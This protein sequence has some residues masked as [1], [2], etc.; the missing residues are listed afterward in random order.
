MFHWF[1]K[2]SNLSKVRQE[3]LKCHAEKYQIPINNFDL[4]DTALTHISCIENNHV[5][6]YERLE[7]LGDSVL[8]LCM[9]SVLYEEYVDLSEG[10]MSVLKSNL[11]D[12]KTL[13]A[14]GRDLE[15]L[16]IVKLGRGEKLSDQRA[17]E[18]VLC[19]I[20]EST[21]AVIFLES[22]FLK[23]RQFVSRIFKS[24]IENAIHGGIQDA[25]TFLQKIAVKAFKEYPVY[26]VIDTEGPDHGKIF[27]VKGAIEQFSATGK[28]RSKKEAEQHV[29]TA[30]LAQIKIYADNNQESVIV[31]EF[32]TY[33]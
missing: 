19:D 24:R 22:G 13:S 6:S 28:G 16:N 27:T 33:K 17:Q 31:K 11:A 20:F 14:I 5:I 32:N 18:K 15:F 21:L 7:F 30:I 8:G 3:I 4:W 29:A 12:E 9:A 25:K 2:K 10:K 23:C 26:E 1:S